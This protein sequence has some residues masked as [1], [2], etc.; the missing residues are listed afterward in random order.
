MFGEQFG[1]C[2]HSLLC[3][4]RACLYHS[5]RNQMQVIRLYG[6]AVLRQIL[7]KGEPLFVVNQRRN[8]CIRI[9]RRQRIG[10]KTKNYE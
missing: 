3:T 7:C 2:S 1:Q 10:H 8:M 6:V 9:L 4:V 5:I